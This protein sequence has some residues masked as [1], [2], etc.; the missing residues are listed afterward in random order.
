[1]S[2]GMRQAAK[3][4]SKRLCERKLKAAT[5][6]M[7]TSGGRRAPKYGDQGLTLSY[8]FESWSDVHCALRERSVHVVEG[9]S[10]SG[11]YL[12]RHLVRPSR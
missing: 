2:H 7:E 10:N 9:V 8:N 5:I 4:I 11:H 12:S 6:L 1:M 3:Q